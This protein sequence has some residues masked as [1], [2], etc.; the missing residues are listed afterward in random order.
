MT[1]CIKERGAGAERRPRRARRLIQALTAAVLVAVCL[2]VPPGA[3]EK[4]RVTNEEHAMEFA[5]SLMNLGRY[6][7]AALILEPLCEE[8]PDLH[9]AA[10]RLADCYIEMGLAGR[11]AE[12]LEERIVRNPD[13]FP[14]ARLL[15]NAYL[16]LGE[17][18]RAVEAWRGALSDDPHLAR[19]YGLVGKLMREAGLYEEAIETYR[20]GRVH[21]ALY[22]L[23][24]IHI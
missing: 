6:E 16:D 11:A 2:P 13:H 12:F 9:N 24:L 20:G 4:G 22:R 7:D 3:Q 8:R 10:E 21:G 1:G 14:F 17:R 19:N 15:G 18:D 23:S 5:A